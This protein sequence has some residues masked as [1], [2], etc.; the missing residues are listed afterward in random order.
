[1]PVEVSS[2]ASFFEW[3]SYKKLSMN[4]VTEIVAFVSGGGLLALG[5]YFTQNRTNNITEFSLLIERYKVIVDTQD[6]KIQEL[7]KLKD[8]VQELRE[9]LSR[10]ESKI[11][12]LETH[13]VD[14]PFP[15]WL[16]DINGVMIALNDPYE[17]EFLK[18]MGKS[19]NQYI[20]KTEF[21]IWPAHLAEEYSRHDK[22]VLKG[23]QAVWTG[24]EHIVV[25]GV[26]NTKSYR[27]IKFKRFAGGMVI[28]TG[29]FAIPI[30]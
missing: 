22:L 8:V 2:Q 9:E 10:M 27:I 15:A 13:Y 6:A 17:E 16:K 20:G 18:P 26:D 11:L 3:C 14:Y 7:E 4:Y 24:D 21:D 28:G 23:K 1:M 12:I 29:G 5:Q 30:P 25:D 19:L